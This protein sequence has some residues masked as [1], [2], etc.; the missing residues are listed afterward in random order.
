M[1]KVTYQGKIIEVVEKE[2]EQDGKI[3]T[4]EFARRSPGTRLIIPK[5]DKII[6][7]KEFRHE[8]GKYDYRLPRG[9][10]FDFFI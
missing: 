6:L 4:F 8:L 7:S 1:E 5:G 9:E 3:Q 10:G 2:V